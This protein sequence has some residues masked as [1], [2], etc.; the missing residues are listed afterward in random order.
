MQ[1]ANCTTPANYFHLLRRQIHRQ[2]RKP[3]VLMEPKNLL[4]EAKSPLW[5]FDDQ[6]DDKVSISSN[7]LTRVPYMNFLEHY[8]QNLSPIAVEGWSGS[9]RRKMGNP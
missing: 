2:F 8:S 9:N 1:V 4:R 6:P 3:L 7:M 5:E